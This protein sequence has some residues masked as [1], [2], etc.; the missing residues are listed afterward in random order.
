MADHDEER[1]K[2]SWRE[3]DQQRDKSARRSDPGAGPAQQNRLERSAAYRDYKTQLNR[4]FDGGKLPEPLRDKLAEAGVGAKQKQKKE[5]AQAIVDAA[6]AAAV[7]GAL[8]TYRDAF[9]FP[10]EES[11]LSRLLE[12]EDEAIVVEAIGCVERLAGDGQLKRAGSLK[13]RIRTAM[14]TL[15]DPDVQAAGK[16]VLEL[17]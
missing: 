10:D 11:V 5:A 2:K 17:L 14:M 3:I 4:L 12:L 15:D 16:R 6:D 9:G 1:P 13:A 8:A 7:R